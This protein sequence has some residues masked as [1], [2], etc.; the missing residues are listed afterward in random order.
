[1][2]QLDVVQKKRFFNAIMAVVVLLAL[3][4][5]VKVVNGVKEHSS[6]DQ[7]SQISVSGTGEVFAI[8]DTG[9]FSFSVT[10]EAKTVTEAQDKA[11]KKVNNIIA[12][13]K[14]MGVDEK[15]IKTVNYSSYPKYE[16]SNS[17]CPPVQPYSSDRPATTVYCPPGKQVLTGY[18]VDQSIAVK[19]RDTE[20][21]GA[22]LTKVG[23]FS[24]GN[25]S[26]L[27]FV[28]DDP[29][30]IQA[31][32]RDKAIADAKAKAKT[33]AKSLGVRL[34]KITSFQENG[35]GYPAPYYGYDAVGKGGV[36][37]QAANPETPVGQNKISSTVVIVYEIR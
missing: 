37:L 36:T 13:L 12:A 14:E 2:D 30:T 21:A 15:D 27:D 6:L 3:F 7:P 35:G 23:S 17:V 29:D 4:L 19:V 25:I 8:P 5:G 31:Q 11:S 24:P 32:A 20:E 9:S 26:G 28:I 33:L 22:I 34:V 18:Q 16:Y 10:E 1:M